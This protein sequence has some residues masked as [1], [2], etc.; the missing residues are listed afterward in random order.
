[1]SPPNDPLVRLRLYLTLLPVFGLPVA[2]WTLYGPAPASPLA[3]QG[4]RQALA[5][6]LV[7]ATVTVLLAGAAQGS[8][9][10]L[11]IL[12]FWLASGF[13]GTGYFMASFWLMVQVFQG[14]SPKLPGL[15][16]LSNRLRDRN[17]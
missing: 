11:V 4:S 8:F 13:V 17:S 7:W 2:L 14:R 1:M 12:R 6:G 15:S 10:H 5:L 9:S 16:G 3:R